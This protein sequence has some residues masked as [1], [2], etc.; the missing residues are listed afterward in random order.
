MGRKPLF[1]NNENF[2]SAED[3]LAYQDFVR[4]EWVNSNSE[5]IFNSQRKKCL[6]RCEDNASLPT[7]KTVRKY[8]FTKE[9]LEPLFDFLLNKIISESEKNENE[10]EN[11]NDNV[12]I[13]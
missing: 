8:K 3:I 2:K 5:K 9:E 10:N 4:Q 6:K 1:R 12:D 13:N 11:D 7:V